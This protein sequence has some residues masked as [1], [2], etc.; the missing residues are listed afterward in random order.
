MVTDEKP[1]KAEKFPVGKIIDSRY[2]VLGYLGHGAMGLVL[3]CA[4]LSLENELCVLKILLHN[5]EVENTAFARF[6]R[7]VVL[8][9]RLSHP[10]IV[11]IYD[12]GQADEDTY[13][14]SMEYI[15]GESLK[16]SLERFLPAGLPLE[17]AVEFLAKTAEGMAYAHKKGVIHRDIKPANILI[18]KDY[19]L[20][21]SDFGVAKSSDSAQKLTATDEAIGSPVYMAPEQLSSNTF[22][23]RADIY[24]F[25]IMAYELLTGH[26]PFYSDHWIALVKMH[27]NDPIPEFPAN[28]N[29][30]LWI[31]ELINKCCA[32]EPEARFQNAEEI[33]E[34][35]AENY[36]CSEWLPNLNPSK[37]KSPNN[38]ITNTYL[39]CSAVLIVAMT[40]YLAFN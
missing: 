12:F 13:Y 23:H 39:I 38:F 24:S 31:E 9:R 34:F 20:R 16:D 10:Y 30:P 4:D 8:S 33:T 22:D 2:K 25:G 17:K 14:I 5:A 35:I 21:I 11:K 40:G 37:A 36:D 18:S 28:L 7:E 19:E 6:K 1:I 29:L 32:K 15:D 27:M 26:P 3:K